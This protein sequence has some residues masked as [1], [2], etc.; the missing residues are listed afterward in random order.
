MTED[1]QPEVKPE[2]KT[3]E[4]SEEQLDKV[5]GGARAVVCGRCKQGV[6]QC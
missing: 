5:A 6:C 4:L 2:A 1:K 3:E